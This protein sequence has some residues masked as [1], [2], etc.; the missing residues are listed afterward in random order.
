MKFCFWAEKNFEL[1]HKMY[2]ECFEMAAGH[3]IFENA[4]FQKFC[5]LVATLSN[6]EDKPDLC[7]CA[8][9]YLKKKIAIDYLDVEAKEKSAPDEEENYLSDL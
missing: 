5:V 1:L 6:L 8:S 4:S 7:R 9:I 3:K 2:I